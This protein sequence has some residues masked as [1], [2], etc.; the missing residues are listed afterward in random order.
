[1][2][3]W[4]AGLIGLAS[5]VASGLFGRILKPAQLPA[6]VSTVSGTRCYATV[7]D[8]DLAGLATWHLVI[9]IPVG[10]TFTTTCEEGVRPTVSTT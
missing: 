4:I 9:A 7:A 3:Y 2:N 5:G 10:V 1:M 8:V 6:F